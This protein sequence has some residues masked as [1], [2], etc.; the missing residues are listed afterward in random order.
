MEL[1]YRTKPRVPV[2]LEVPRLTSE[3]ANFAQVVVGGLAPS[4]TQRL[5]PG[6]TLENYTW[7]IEQSSLPYNA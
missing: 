6:F 1:D 3:N 5:R 7:Q 4:P 2:L